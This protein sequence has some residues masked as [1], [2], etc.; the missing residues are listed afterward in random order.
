MKTLRFSSWHGILIFIIAALV[1]AGCS[2]NHEGEKGG[3]VAITFWHSCVSSTVPALNDLIARFEQEHPDIE[4]KAQ[5]VPTGDA[6]VQKLITSVQ[7]K[8]APDISWIHANFLQSIIDADAIDKMDEFI[9][10]A[11]SLSAADLADIFPPLME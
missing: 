1:T 11:D 4:I 9:H 6:L 5:Y 10:G 8:T 7:S 2:G 3:K